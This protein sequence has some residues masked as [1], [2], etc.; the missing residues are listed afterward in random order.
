MRS[1]YAYQKVTDEFTTYLIQG[2]AIELATIDGI[3]YVSVLGD[4]PPQ[5]EQLS[6]ALADMTPE[7]QADLRKCDQC[8][9]I[10][11][12]TVAKIR[13]HYSAE[14]EIKAIR[15]GGSAEADWKAYVESCVAEGEAAK[16]EL[17]L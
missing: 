13:E 10:N 7:L 2:D 3:T 6:V 17:G 4:L 9:G 12:I 11:A 1:I 16:A 8:K 15:L 14:D 5:H